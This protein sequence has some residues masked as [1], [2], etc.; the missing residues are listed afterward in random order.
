MALALAG[1]GDHASAVRAAASGVHKVVHAA[2]PPAAP[3]VSVTLG[4]VL[5]RSAGG[6]GGNNGS[7]STPLSGAVHGGSGS[8][9][10]S[11]SASASGS[12]AAALQR[13]LGAAGAPGPQLQLYCTPA[14]KPPALMPLMDT[15]LL[16]A[17]QAHQMAPAAALPAPSPGPMSAK[18]QFVLSCG[19]AGVKQGGELPADLAALAAAGVELER[20]SLVVVSCPLPNI[21]CAVVAYASVA[22]AAGERQPSE[23]E[24]ACVR[25]HLES[26]TEVSAL[27]E[28]VS[29]QPMARTRSQEH[30][31]KTLP[32][33]SNVLVVCSVAICSCLLPAWSSGFWPRVALRWWRRECAARWGRRWRLGAVAPVQVAP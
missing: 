17:P 1:G 19:D 32:C 4:L 14:G 23:A 29:R 25:G 21:L 3:P 12:A 10:A 6:G 11:V 28:H 9:S 26:A 33:L 13:S 24:L 27:G 18:R 7:P 16:R 2:L 31:C 15:L 5:S 8:G 30:C 22:T 20:S